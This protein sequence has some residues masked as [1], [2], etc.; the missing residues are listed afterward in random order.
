MYQ[1]YIVVG[2]L[3][4]DAEQ[5]FT[6]GENAKSV[7]SFRPITSKK[8]NGKEYSFSIN[9][10]LWGKLGEA[11]VK[12]LKK[13][14]LVLVEG[15]LRQDKWE[16]DGVTHYKTFVV[17]D[18]VRLLGKSATTE[19]SNSQSAPQQSGQPQKSSDP[20]DVDF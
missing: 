2:R 13:G 5:R 16:K 7:V 8:V 1:K 9:V 4:A 6:N 15:E 10:D 14:Q 17:A 18:N 19:S 20:F 11:I 12:Y 3:A